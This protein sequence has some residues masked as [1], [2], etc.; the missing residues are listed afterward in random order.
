MMSTEKADMGNG[1]VNTVDSEI[2]T[3]THN[4][5]KCALSAESSDTGMA[6]SCATSKAP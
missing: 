4:V 5:M 2:V 1:E 3:P 6:V